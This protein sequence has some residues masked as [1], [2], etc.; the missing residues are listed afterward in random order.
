VPPILEGNA[1]AGLNLYSTKPDGF[2][3]SDI[4][5]VETYSYHVSKAL[6]LAVRISRLAE[7]KAN[8]IANLGPSSTWRPA[9]S[10]HRTAATRRRL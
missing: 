9:Q 8:L 10:W 5:M 3:A 2:T 6:R 4:S 7:A 1:A